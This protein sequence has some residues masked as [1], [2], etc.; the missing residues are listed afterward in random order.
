MHPSTTPGNANTVVT[1]QILIKNGT[2]NGAAS[3]AFLT[4]SYVPAK[5]KCIIVKYR[6]ETLCNEKMWSGLS[7]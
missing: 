4:T 6:I 7:A 1:F 5:T 2:A 3:N